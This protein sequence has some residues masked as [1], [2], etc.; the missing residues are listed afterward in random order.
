MKHL[1]LLLWVFS[2]GVVG[3][4][5]PGWHPSGD[6]DWKQTFSDEFDAPTLDETRWFPGYRLGRM[7]YYKKIGFPNE[8]GRAWQPQPPMAHYVLQ[9][10]VLKLRVDKDL[11]KRDKPETLTV[12]CLTTAIYRYNEATRNFDDEVKFS[13]KYG[14]FE[15]RCKMPNCGS[16]RYTAFWLHQVGAKNQEYTPEGVR[17][18]SAG[19]LEIDIFEWLGGSP[20][21][22]LF[23]VHFTPNG[24][25]R[26]PLDFDAT[27]EYHVWAMH[28]EEGKLTWYLDGK[29][30]YT[31]QGQTPPG[32]MYLLV[33]MFQAASWTGPLDTSIPYPVDFEIDYIRVWNRK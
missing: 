15:I 26:F 21:E 3:A 1:L 6:L 5:V 29:P 18:S 32:P 20:K 8:H 9:D 2:C 19:A 31:Y 7:E 25:F 27:K 30:I 11:P 4:E 13:Q 24:H 14:W 23:N 16:G 33:A 17:R 28:W 10:G 12:S 22:N